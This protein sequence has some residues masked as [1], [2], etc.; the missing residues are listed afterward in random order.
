MT[1][2]LQN[3]FSLGLF[4]TPIHQSQSPLLH[5]I[6]AK[7]VGFRLSDYHLLSCDRS[8]AQSQYQKAIE[9]GLKGASVTIPLKD[10]A[11]EIVKSSHPHQPLH[12]SK[13]ASDLKTVNALRWDE[14]GVYGH[15]TDVIGFEKSLSLSTFEHNFKHSPIYQT[16][17]LLGA[18]GASRAVCYALLKMGVHHITWLCRNHDHHIKCRSFFDEMCLNLSIN[19]QKVQLSILDFL[20]QN[21]PSQVDICIFT[22]PPLDLAFYQEIPFERIK[23]TNQEQATLIY[24]LNYGTRADLLKQVVT[25]QA[26]EDFQYQ[27]GLHMLC[28]QGI[29][30]FEWFHQIEIS[31]TLAI[32][33]RD[34]FR[35]KLR[36]NSSKTMNF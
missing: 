27:D 35:E 5:S 17:V 19:P 32:Q 28:D 30:A 13:L 24:D 6:I 26:F 4:G 2:S 33:I 8:E 20:P 36:L 16:A 12:L 1:Q 10:W 7:I 9:L 34:E 23:K 25:Q 15:N 22:T 31:Q 21:L 3:S 14:N 18:G 29:S 11:Y